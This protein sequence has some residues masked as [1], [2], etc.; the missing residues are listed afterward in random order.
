MFDAFSE[1]STKLWGRSVY[2]AWPGRELGQILVIVDVNFVFTS[3]RV[4]T[5]FICCVVSSII[6]L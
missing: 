3:I 5:S 4:G 1:V 2:S 6:A